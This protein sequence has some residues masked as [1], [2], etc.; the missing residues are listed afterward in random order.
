M[1][2]GFEDDGDDFRVGAISKIADT[3]RPMFGQG[4]LAAQVA[5]ARAETGRMLEGAGMSRDKPRPPPSEESVG[6]TYEHKEIVVSKGIVKHLMTREHAQIILEEAG[7][8]VEWLPEKAKAKMT[9]AP[10]SLKRAARLLARVEM[11]CNWGSSDI[12]VKKLLG[13]LHAESVLVRLSP[14]TVTGLVPAEKTLSVG[15]ERIYIGKDKSNDVLCHDSN[16]SRQ[17]CLLSFDEAK[18]GVYVTDLSTN[19]TF[20][21]GVRL[22]NKKLG[23]VLLCHG[24]ELL[25]K[26]PKT[27]DTE[28]GYMCNLKDVRLRKE[29]RKQV[30]RRLLTPEEANSTFQAS[31]KAL[32]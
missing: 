28:F 31:F 1:K 2:R 14:M 26:D 16:V 29:V 30:P 8:E 5:L 13:R 15:C 25:L 7:C 17:H 24:D 9:G 23:K 12:K 22:P 3:T 4:D 20:L 6:V 18:G 19:G 32:A 21:N 27:G 11:H 10:E